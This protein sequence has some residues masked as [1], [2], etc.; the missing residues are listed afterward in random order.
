MGT[1]ENEQALRKIIDMIRMA[2][3]LVLGM[4]FYVYCHLGLTTWGYT[5]EFI[6]RI[7]LNLSRAGLFGSVWV[8]KLFALCLLVVSLIGVRGKKDEEISARATVLYIVSGLLLFL[9]G[10][11]WLML[12][13]VKPATILTIAT[14]TIGYIL[15]L[16]GGTLLSRLIRV[17]IGQDI[18]NK[19]NETFPQEER[20]IENEYSINLPAQYRFR[21]ATRKSF[22]SF[23]N[24]FRS[25]LV[26][27]SPGSG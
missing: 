23:I 18:F 8:S 11:C 25:L 15:L 24:P 22:I 14:T 3:I 1:G 20:K 7:M 26:L 6:D 10:H 17:K 12:E 9:S 5:V 27:G 21:G 19:E 2:S 4:H 16:T 13:A